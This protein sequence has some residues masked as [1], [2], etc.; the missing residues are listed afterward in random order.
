MCNYCDVIITSCVIIMIQ[1]VEQRSVDGG[2]VRFLRSHTP[3]IEF[4][5][6]GMR[7][8]LVCVCV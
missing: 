7:V 4:L 2:S 6:M 3:M 1:I 8:S 5:G